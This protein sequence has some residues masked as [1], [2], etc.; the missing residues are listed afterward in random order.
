MLLH[1]VI[2]FGLLVAQTDTLT[3]SGTIFD[4]G[5]HPLGKARVRAEELT[6]RKQ[7]EVSTESDGTF[8]F[9][10]LPYGTYRLTIEK[11]G[12]FNVSTEIRLE[13]SESV[14]FTLTEAEKVKQDVNVVARP[15]PINPDSVSPQLTVNNEVVQNIVYPGR[16]NF[17]NALA[18]MPGV[19][20]DDSGQLHIQGGRT[21]QIRYQLD[22]MNLTNATAGGLTE[23]IPLDAI[24]SIDLDLAGY[25]AEFGKGSGGVVRVHS[26]LTGDKYKFNVTDFVPGISLRRRS[27]SEFSPRLLFS[28]P[29]ARNKVWFMYAASFRYASNWV[30]GL[31]APDNQQRQTLSDELLKLQWNVRESHVVS[32]DVIFN[33]QFFSN[34]GLSVVRPLDT[35]T[36]SRGHGTTLAV[37]DR[38]TFGGTLVETMLQWTR[39]RNSNLAKG[40]Q[41]LE[42]GPD[43][44]TGNYYADQRVYDQRWHASESVSWEKR[45]GGLTHRFKVGGE[46]DNVNSNLRLDRRSFQLLDDSGD[47][48]SSVSFSG[49]DFTALSNQEYGAFAQDRIILSP[50]LQMEA[51]LRYDRERQADRNNLAPR[52]GFSFLPRKTLQSKISGGVGLFYDNLTLLNIEMSQLQRRYTTAYNNGVPVAAPAPTAVKVSPDLRDPYAVHWN[53]AWENEWAPRWV[54]RVE[55]IQKA[56]REDSRLAAVPAADGFNLLFNNSG[57]SDYRAVEFIF[58]RPVR[59]DLRILASYTHSN[60]KARPSMSLDFPDP[61]VESVGEVPVEWNAVHR[62]VS[63]GYFPLPAHLYGSFAVEARSGFPFTTV[64]DLNHVVGPYNSNRMPTFFSTDASLEK[65]LPIPFENGKRVAVRIGVTNLFNH[66]NPRTVDPNIDSSSFLRFTDAPRRRFVLR[67]RILKK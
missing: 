47:L 44:W 34:N 9:D 2:L 49:P 51:G 23:N 11:G 1:T 42:I 61:A 39:T 12:Y 20:R 59:T 32:L 21:D 26:Q 7:W 43:L 4:P 15:E 31:L 28:G 54:S 30:E 64:D 14:E 67:L 6:E 36:D 3:L 16:L 40:T 48:R 22:G 10:R 52:F 24:E 29:V 65:Q 56:G 53:V 27:I 58:D 35:T 17:T 38:H 57:K 63:W 45:T 66:F 13:S 5:A 33:T 60:A 18:L 46:F 50:A 55:Y 19:L 41:P 37:S 8:R 25:S 62:F